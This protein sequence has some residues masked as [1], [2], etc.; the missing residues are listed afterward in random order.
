MSEWRNSATGGRYDRRHWEVATNWKKKRVEQMSTHRLSRAAMECK[1]Q[2]QRGLEGLRQDGKIY[3]SFGC[4]I[5][6]PKQNLRGRTRLKCLGTFNYR[7]TCQASLKA[8][9][10]N[11]PSHKRQKKI[12]RPA[13]AVRCLVLKNKNRMRMTCLSGIRKVYK[14][15]TEFFSLLSRLFQTNTKTMVS[16]RQVSP[17]SSSFVIIIQDISKVIWRKNEKCRLFPWF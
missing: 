3:S 13:H 15:N 14:S 4:Y 6:F 2:E 10:W 1:P 17:S 8:I 16:R 11:T 12:L 5:H 7:S 9:L